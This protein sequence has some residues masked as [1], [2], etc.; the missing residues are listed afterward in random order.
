LLFD[1][2]LIPNAELGELEHPEGRFEEVSSGRTITKHHRSPRHWAERAQPCFNELDRLLSPARWIVA[3]GLS[4]S[5]DEYFALVN[6]AKPIRV[7]HLG[8]HSGIVGAAAATIR[9]DKTRLNGVTP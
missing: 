6:L 8:R 4:G 7:A 9:S 1:G 2:R 5:F 3:G